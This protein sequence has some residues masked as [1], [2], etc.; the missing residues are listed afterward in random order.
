MATDLTALEQ[1][2]AQL[3]DKAAKPTADLTQATAE[4]QAARLAEEER[5][6]ARR[7]EWERKFYEGWKETDQ[8]LLEEYKQARRDFMD[9][10]RNDPMWSAWLRLQ[11]TWGRRN[12]LRQYVE[13]MIPK[14][15]PDDVIPTALPY[16]D[17]DAVW[18]IITAT[19]HRAGLDASDVE[20]GRIE[21]E[22][23]TYAEGTD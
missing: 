13:G 22:R 15:A 9:A 14:H 1:R 4:L 17:P 10:L 23:K 20:S 7:D 5:Q 16:S 11:E 18:K 2:V 3:A 21:D 19:I 12:A 6:T 8:Q